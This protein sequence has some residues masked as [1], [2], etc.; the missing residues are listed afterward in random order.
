[1]VRPA[2]LK[3]GFRKVAEEGWEVTDDVSIIERMGQPVKLTLGE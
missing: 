2:A 3:E 1:M